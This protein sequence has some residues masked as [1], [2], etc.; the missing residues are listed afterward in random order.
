MYHSVIHAYRLYMIRRGY[1]QE[2]VWARCSIAR[3]WLRRS[4]DWRAATFRDVEAWLAESE[5][6]PGAVRNRVANLRAW[7]RW[8][9][10]EGL[11]DTDPTLLVDMPRLPQ[12]LPRPARED[13]IG[14]VLAGADPAVAAMIGLMAGAGLR[15]VECSRLDWR[16]VDLAAGQIIVMGKGMKER[17]LEL[18]PAIV[19]LLAAL[20]GFDGPVFVG[21]RGGRLSPARIS[22]TVCR[23][24]RH[25]GYPTTSHQLRHRFATAA[26]REPEADI[27]VVRQLLGHANVGTTQIYAEIVPGLS[28]RV[29]RGMDL[30]PAA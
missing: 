20:D 12:R 21:V 9:I 26:L 7:Y 22:Q 2:T 10:R 25:A 18:A 8:A 27:M 15:C 6:C 14:H 28:G 4:I 24:F 16:D 5:L 1:A 23:A 11:C 3:Q 19:R 30:P 13:Q 17:S 29:S